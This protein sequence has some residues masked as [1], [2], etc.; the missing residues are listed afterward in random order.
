MN[1]PDEFD[2]WDDLLTYIRDKRV[3]PIIG[4]ELLKVNGPSGPT[5]LYRIVAEQLAEQLRIPMDGLAEERPLD[6]VVTRYMANHGRRDRLYNRVSMVLDNL[7]VNVPE[8]LRQL[9]AIPELKL[10]VTTTC[11]SMIETALREARPSAVIRRL[12]Y[13]PGNVKDLPA[14]VDPDEVIVYH[15]L[16]V[17]SS[18]PTFVL[19]DEDLLE[20]IYAMQRDKPPRLFDE[21]SRHHLLFIGTSF[22]DWLARLF[23]RLAKGMRLSQLRDYQ[24]FLADNAM[25]CDRN[26]VMF[27]RCFSHQTEI[28]NDGSAE[29][30]V[31]ELHRRYFERFKNSVSRPSG[32]G[33]PELEENR[34]AAPAA[35]FISYAHEDL[36]AAQRIRD[37]LQQAGID[38]W[39][40]KRTLEG[41]DD[42]DMKIGRN[43]RECILFIPIISATTTRRTEGYFRGEWRLANQRAEHIADGVPFIIP[44]AID[45]TPESEAAVVPHRFLTL[46]WQ[47][48]PAGAVTPEYVKR[49]V[50]LVRDHRARREG[51]RL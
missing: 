23:L 32:L 38:V 40:D 31:S 18:A 9:A 43:I 24:E 33:S 37:A 7:R 50:E 2:L 1:P 47:R 42:Y 45:N 26:L 51:A 22:P 13:A 16:G 21:L 30:F 25:G 46:H 27:L 49:I 29:K 3:V 5:N 14:V 41:G 35:V 36:I 6:D 39:F 17:R 8:P 19:T 34:S 44:T 11:D 12:D 48:L 10:F 4:H 20:F 28:Y 15:L